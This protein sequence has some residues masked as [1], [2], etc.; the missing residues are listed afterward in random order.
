MPADIIIIC[1]TGGSGFAF[2]KE[3]K[4]N[5]YRYNAVLVSSDTATLDPG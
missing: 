3:N 4:L 1:T 5:I 2:V